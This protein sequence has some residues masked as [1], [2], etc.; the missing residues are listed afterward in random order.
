MNPL[1]YAPDSLGYGIR[2]PALVIS[3]CAIT[4]SV[5]PQVRS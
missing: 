1:S 3:P 5:D 4:G 2:I